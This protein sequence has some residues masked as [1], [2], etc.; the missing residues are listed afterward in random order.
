LARFAAN[1]TDQPAR[2][3]LADDPGQILLDDT[4]KWERDQG[5]FGFRWLDCVP[6]RLIRKRLIVMQLAERGG[7]G[8]SNY[9]ERGISQLL[10]MSGNAARSLVQL[11]FLRRSEFLFVG[12]P[13]RRLESGLW[14]DPFS[15]PLIEHLGAARCACV[16][17]PFFGRHY[18]PAKTRRVAY[19]DGILLLAAGASRIASWLVAPF[20]RQALASLTG[21]LGQRLALPE[22]RLRMMI[23]AAAIEHRVESAGMRLL[24]AVVRPRCIFLTSRW[25]H[26]PL[27]R[28]AR[29]KGVRVIELQHGAVTRGGYAYA[30]PYDP[31]FD[32]DAMLTFGPYWND[33]DWGI[34]PENVADVGYRYIWLRR[35]QSMGAGRRGRKVLLISKPSRNAYLSSVFMEI[36]RRFPE[37]D[38]VLRLHPQDAFRWESRYPVGELPNVRV[39]TEAHADLYDVF[40]ECD[41]VI[42]DESTVLYEAAFFGLTVAILNLDGRNTSPALAFAGSFGFTEVRNPDDL[43]SLLRRETR[44]VDPAEGNPFFSDFDAARFDEILG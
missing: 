21:P 20:S 36:V 3:H 19:L 13:R 1:V 6:W 12:F 5:L 17:K 41:L 16:E 24:L 30:T 10:R 8:R 27:I 34:D 18:R 4:L 15:D 25:V 33:F 22:R 35:H 9:N 42:G 31:D 40:T 14:V 11:L 2:E 29:R 28:A 38:F 43:E 23:V 44:S 37:R 39:S 32:P 26:A 7:R